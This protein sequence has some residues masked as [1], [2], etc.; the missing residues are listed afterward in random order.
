M[1]A[2]KW[3]VLKAYAEAKNLKPQLSAVSANQ[4][5]FT[6][7]KGKSV[8]V[9]YLTMKKFVERQSKKDKEA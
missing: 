8:T 5:S 7:A 1:N 3:K 4:F 6:N 2:E 9:G